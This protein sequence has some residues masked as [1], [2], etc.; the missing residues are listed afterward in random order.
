MHS[1]QH[2]QHHMVYLIIISLYTLVMSVNAAVVQYV[3]RKSRVR[4]GVMLLFLLLVVVAAVIVVRIRN[5]VKIQDKGRF[6]EVSISNIKRKLAANAEDIGIPAGE[7]ESAIANEIKDIEAK[8]KAGKL[9]N[10]SPLPNGRCGKGYSM[11]NGCC[12][13]HS[14]ER[15]KTHEKLQLAGGIIKDIGISVV[16][17]LIVEKALMKGLTTRASRAATSRAAVGAAKAAKTAAAGAAKAVKNAVSIAKAARAFAAA[18]KA[19]AAGA[20]YAVAASGGPVGLMVTAAL[21]AFDAISITLDI[22]DVDG[23]D[24]FTSQGLLT[25]MK[26]IIDSSV[27]KEF[28][29]NDIKYPM[30]FPISI[31]FPEEMALAQEYMNAQIIEKYLD[32]EMAKNAKVQSAFDKYIQDIIENPDVEQPVPKEYI[33]FIGELYNIKHL[34]RDRAVYSKLKELL[35]DQAYKI[36]FYESISGPDQMGISLSPEGAKEWNS[37][38]Q[39]IWLQNN[40][41]FNPPDPDTLKIPDEPAAC[42]TDTYYV[43]TSGTADKPNMSPKKLP[44]KTV[45]AN[46][47]GSLLAFC[48][49]TRKMKGTSTGVDP[50]A[51]GTRFNFDTGVCEF[52]K[53]M[54]KRYGL[55]FKN[56]DCKP[57]PGQGVAELIF[58]TTITRA[59][60]KEYSQR[61]DDFKSGDPEKI[62]IALAKTQLD[63]MTFGLGSVILTETLKSYAKKSKPAT[64]GDCPSGM[65]DDGVNCWLDPYKIPTGTIPNTCRASEPTKIGARCYEDCP[66]GYERNEAVPTLCEPKCGGDYPLKRGLVCYEDC[67]DRGENWKNDSLLMCKTKCPSGSRDEGLRCKQN[68]KTSSFVAL[69]HRKHCYKKYGGT[70]VVSRAAST[71]HEPCLPGFHLVSAAWGSGHCAKNHS[72]RL[73]KSKSIFD[74]G[75]TKER[76]SHSVKCP[77]GK[78]ERGGLCYEPCKNKGPEGQYKYK[79]VL[80]WCQPEGGAGIKKGL[81]DRMKCPD[82]WERKG[83][84]CYQPCKEGERDDGLFCK[85]ME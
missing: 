37:E 16:A 84:L 55:E 32:I 39:E 29:K 19:A 59:Y 20:K 2:H 56:N 74:F 62:M 4:F 41:L 5:A 52:S 51:L 17:G 13:P 79:G 76:K 8:E 24:S 42:Y 80:D 11:E 46:Y 22:L 1:W 9:C 34:E 67:T 78:E 40:D 58:G 25:N 7:L 14:S 21:L 61:L 77:D 66:D 44:E 23:Y 82:G 50:K 72:T 31:L 28:E 48:E 81:D 12:Y 47:Y 64:V 15:N 45:I 49:K 54:C 83:P 71:C 70:G 57:R 10:I 75:K 85:R 73:R 33:D 69:T 38:N 68:I 6:E 53:D 3:Q 43:Y 26:N 27:A 30:L 60:I 18:G 63:L 35:G 65:R 36:S